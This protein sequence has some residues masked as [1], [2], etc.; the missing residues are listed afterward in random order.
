MNVDRQYELDRTDGRFR[1]IQRF[2]DMDP[3]AGLVRRVREAAQALNAYRRVRN[4]PMFGDYEYI[5]P[6]RISADQFVHDIEDAAGE[7]DDLDPYTIA[8]V[9]AGLRCQARPFCRGC[10]TCFTITSPH[11]SSGENA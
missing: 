10:P 8:W 5:L 6:I 3:R 4:Q 9:L 2:L 11:R 7:R 1:A